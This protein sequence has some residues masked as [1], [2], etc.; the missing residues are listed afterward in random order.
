MRHF[1]RMALTP[2]NFVKFHINICACMYVCMYVHVSVCLCVYSLTHSIMHMQIATIVPTTSG[3]TETVCPSAPQL[4][5][6]LKAT[7]EVDSANS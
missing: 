3:L 1:R 7:M 6:L 4:A 2:F 5:R